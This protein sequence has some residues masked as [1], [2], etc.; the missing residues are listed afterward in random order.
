MS[1]DLELEILAL[2][3]S[4]Y[5]AKVLCGLDD[6][7]I[8]CYVTAVKGLHMEKELPPPHTVPIMKVHKK[9]EKEAEIIPESGNILR[10]ADA[11]MEMG[12]KKQYKFYPDGNDAVIEVN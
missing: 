12:S 3:G 9:G 8:P 2:V 7:G 6:R 5:V 10:W 1:G 4:Q 11:H